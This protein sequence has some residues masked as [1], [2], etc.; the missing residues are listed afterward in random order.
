MRGK[1]KG[2]QARLL[3]KNPCAFFVPFGAHT[4]N[5]VL[6]DAAK[7]SL[8]ASSYFGY[9]Q[10]IYCL[11]SAAPQRWA[12]LKKHVEISVKGWTET[13]W[14]SRI[15][16]VEAQRYQAAEVREALL[17]VREKTTDGNLRIESQP[18]AE[19]IGSF[20]F[21]ICSVVCGRE[22]ALELTNLPELPSTKVTQLSILS[23]IHSQHL[24]EV[25]PNL[26][27]ALRIGLTLPVTVTGA[28]RSFSKL[29]LIKTYLRSTM[30]QEHLVG[31]AILSI[32]HETS[33]ELKYDDVINDFAAKRSRKVKT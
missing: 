1:H 25:F 23:F 9:L 4:L 30:S 26:W 18:L 31:L 20:R 8:D 21:S 10:K 16:S 15:K 29:K 19:E 17:E 28:E 11:F 2:I 14:E 13:R 22:L 12:I 27:T 7:A 32:N 6:A 3:D 33:E 24:T 5:L